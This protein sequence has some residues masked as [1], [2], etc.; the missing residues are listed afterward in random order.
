MHGF[1][2]G[3]VIYEY[4]GWIFEYGMMSGPWP[5]TKKYDPRKN[6]GRRFWKM[7]DDWNA[8]PEEEKQKTRI[9]GGCQRF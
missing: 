4:K 8:L 1:M 5:L 3:P 9:G 6:A 7:F 2:C